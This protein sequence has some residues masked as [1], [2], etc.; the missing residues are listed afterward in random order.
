MKTIKL[1]K[2]Y[3]TIVDDADYGTTF[4]VSMARNCP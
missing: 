2:G 4:G 3:F 1:T